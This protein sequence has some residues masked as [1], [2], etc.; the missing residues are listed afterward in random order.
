MF[1]FVLKYV[2][3]LYRQLS[4]KIKLAKMKNLTKKQI[5]KLKNLV[6]LNKGYITTSV[7]SIKKSK[8]SMIVEVLAHTQKESKSIFVTLNSKLQFISIDGNH[9]MPTHLKGNVSIN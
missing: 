7:A 5:E 2:V 6:N 4:Q 9:S 8:E 3:Y 1:T